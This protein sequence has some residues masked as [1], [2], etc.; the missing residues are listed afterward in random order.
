M[1]MAKVPLNWDGDDNPYF[2]P[3][4]M[5]MAAEVEVEHDWGEW[6]VTKEA[7]E[8]EE[9][10]KGDTVSRQITAESTGSEICYGVV[11]SYYSAI[12]IVCQTGTVP[13]CQKLRLYKKVLSPLTQ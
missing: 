3:D 2:A 6:V 12:I 5:I 7:T 11:L 13:L 9:G 1:D 8:T 10:Y 4:R